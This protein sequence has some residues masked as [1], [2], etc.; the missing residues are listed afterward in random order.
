MNYLTKFNDFVNESKES[1]ALAKEINKAM[2]RI[3]GEMSYKDFAAAVA[4]ILRDEYGK[5]N[6]MPFIEELK[7]QL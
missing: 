6:Y 4:T 5:H 7:K 3:V 2:I 1:D